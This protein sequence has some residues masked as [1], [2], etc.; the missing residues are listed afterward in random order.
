V[1]QQRAEANDY[2]DL[3]TILCAGIG[4][5][6]SL[7]AA[8][9]IYGPTFNPQITLKSLCFFDDGDLRKLP[10]EMKRRLVKAVAETDLDRLPSLEPGDAL[11]TEGAGFKP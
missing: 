5:P 2:V 11:E 1:V 9:V 6:K 4:L 3:D 7:A 10:E 8:K